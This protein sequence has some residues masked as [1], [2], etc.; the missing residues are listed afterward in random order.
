[1][2]S[3]WVKFWM[4]LWFHILPNELS[5]CIHVRQSVHILK[6]IYIINTT[7]MYVSLRIL[8]PDPIDLFFP[9]GDNPLLLITKHNVLQGSDITLFQGIRSTFYCD[10]MRE[11]LERLVGHQM[12]RLGSSLCIRNRVGC[13]RLMEWWRAR[14]QGTEKKRAGCF[15]HIFL[16][17]HLGSHHAVMSWW[18]LV[19]ASTFLLEAGASMWPCVDG[20]PGKVGRS[21][22][23]SFSEFT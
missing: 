12:A 3:F 1:M 21:E 19:A 20:V 18:W 14:E 6:Y 15:A 16:L 2:L 17:L 9:K 8:M 22:G 11:L 5:D 10:L 4:V 7:L 23:C 13:C